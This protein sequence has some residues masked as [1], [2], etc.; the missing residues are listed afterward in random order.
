[1]TLC[2]CFTPSAYDFTFAL[3]SAL[4]E[5]ILAL[6]RHRHTRRPPTIHCNSLSLPSHAFPLLILSM[7]ILYNTIQFRHD[8]ILFCSCAPGC[9][10]FPL[11]HSSVP[12]VYHSFLF[13]CYPLALLIITVAVR[14]QPIPFLRSAFPD[15]SSPLPR[16]A[17]LYLAV[18][19]LPASLPL[20]SASLLLAGKTLL[21]CS[22]WKGYSLLR[23]S[24]LGNLT[25]QSPGSLSVR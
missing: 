8:T 19:L 5:P 2:A 21:L 12:S 18:T 7:R 20:L 15:R 10:A 3:P 24:Q 25:S 11:P 14:R 17:I 6:L 22:R 1:M 4:Y 16:F 23:L 13:H 9:F